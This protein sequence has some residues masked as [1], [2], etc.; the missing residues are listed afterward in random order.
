VTPSPLGST[1]RLHDPKPS[2][3]QRG[4]AARVAS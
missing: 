3:I 1:T 4:F 2:A